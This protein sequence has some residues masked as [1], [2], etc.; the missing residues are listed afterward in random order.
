MYARRAKEKN[1]VKKQQLMVKEL[2]ESKIS[3][4]TMEG[5]NVS[6]SE[7]KE[8]KML[9]NFDKDIFAPESDMHRPNYLLEDNPYSFFVNFERL[10][11]VIDKKVKQV[12]YR[13]ERM[14]RL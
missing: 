6:L 7:L 10:P 11:K 3:L 5:A 13:P 9:V 12:L 4:K 14:A 8:I 2:L 1:E